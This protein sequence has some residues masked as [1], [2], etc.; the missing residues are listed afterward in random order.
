LNGAQVTDFGQDV[1]DGLLIVVPTN[2]PLDILGIKYSC[3]NGT[4]G[5]P[6]IVATMEVSDLSNIPVAS[7]WRMNFTAN[8]PFTQLSPTGAYSF[9]LSDRG[10]QFFVRATTDAAGTQS[11]SYGTAV[12]NSDGSLS[13]TTRG[14]ADSGKFDPGHN[15]ITVKVSAT[16]LNAFVTHGPLIGVGSTFAG[17]RGQTFTAGVNAKR[18]I[19]RGGTQFTIGSCLPNQGG[20]GG[21][22][23]GNGP[24]VKVTGGGSIDGKIRSFTLNVDR[25]PSGNFKFRD[26]MDNFSLNSTSISSYAQT[27]PNQVTFSGTGMIDRDTVTFDVTVEDNGEKGTDDFF[28]ISIPARNYS[29]SGT[30]SQGNIQAH[31]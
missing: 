12:R 4:D 3:E 16:K 24:I 19:A 30:L 17:L 28:K 15:T 10:D 26:S 29:H 1:A 20:G 11:F 22:V 23:G 7:N 6:V 27:G 5:A 21:G 31:R 9:G 14:A 25:T 18:D 8:A 13:Y 2:D